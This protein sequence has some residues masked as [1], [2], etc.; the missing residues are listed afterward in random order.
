MEAPGTA[1]GSATLIP[2]RVY[3]HS[4]RSDGED[5]GVVARNFEGKE[6][7]KGM[8]MSFSSPSAQLLVW[9]EVGTVRPQHPHPQTIKV[10]AIPCGGWLKAIR[11]P[12]PI[13]RLTGGS[14]CLVKA[15]WLGCLRPAFVSGLSEKRLLSFQTI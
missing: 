14:E 11:L 2:S 5:I 4:H 7:E 1:P 13:P 6:K 10:S 15:D 12:Q 8:Y 9:H 3:R